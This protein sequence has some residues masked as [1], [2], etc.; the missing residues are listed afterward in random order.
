MFIS[1]TKNKLNLQLKKSKIQNIQID[2][3]ERLVKDENYGFLI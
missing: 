2:R 1:F 3:M